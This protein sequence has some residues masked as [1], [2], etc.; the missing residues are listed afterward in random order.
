MRLPVEYFLISKALCWL[1][2]SPS[3]CYGLLLCGDRPNQS[4]QCLHCRDGE[5][6][7]TP[8]CLCFLMISKLTQSR[9]STWHREGVTIW[10][11][12]SSSFH[13][14]S[15][16]PTWFL[17]SP[18]NEWHLQPVNYLVTLFFENSVCVT[19]WHSLPLPGVLCSWEWVSS[20]IGPGWF[21]VASCLVLSRFENWQSSP[22]LAAWFNKLQASIFSS[23]VFVM[24]T[25][26]AT[27]PLC[28]L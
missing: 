13:I 28:Y 27:D 4:R 18:A 17:L 20:K 1:A 7:C 22:V 26:C 2:H 24:T 8:P 19:G 25:W 11:S 5:W 21:S 23:V 6:P 10:L 14:H 12:A 3:P 16:E 15:C 9:H